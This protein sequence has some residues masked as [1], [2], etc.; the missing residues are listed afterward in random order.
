[1]RTPR[2]SSPMGTS[3]SSQGSHKC[4]GKSYTAGSRALVLV[5]ATLNLEELLLPFAASLQPPGV[6]RATTT[7]ELSGITTNRA[8]PS[9]LV[10]GL[11]TC[12]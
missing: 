11:G 8:Q 10:L 3:P 12:T 5:E 2:V 9:L 1:V 7:N 6:S 4:L